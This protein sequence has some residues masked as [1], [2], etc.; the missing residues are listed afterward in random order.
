VPQLLLVALA[1]CK[2]SHQAEHLL[3]LLALLK[4]KSLS[5]AE[6]VVAHKQLLTKVVVVVAQQLKLFQGLLLVEL[7]Q[8]QLVVVEL[9]A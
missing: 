2:Y 7:L 3:S 8:L 9:V 1:I 6:V 4:L 5:L